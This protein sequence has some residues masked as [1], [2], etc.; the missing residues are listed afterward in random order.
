MAITEFILNDFDKSQGLWLRLREHMEERLAFA[1]QC[2][3]KVQPEDQTAVLRGEI[4]CLK[5]LIALGDDRPVVDG[6]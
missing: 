4:K 3:D 6:P 2:N 5:G 1:R